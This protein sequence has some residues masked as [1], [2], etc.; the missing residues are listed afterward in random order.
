MKFKN[1]PVQMGKG[2]EVG[3]A[4]QDGEKLQEV[5]I[6][7]KILYCTS[8]YFHNLLYVYLPRKQIH[9]N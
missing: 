6:G 9:L 1:Y 7:F 3:R 4:L 5:R 8:V 2:Q